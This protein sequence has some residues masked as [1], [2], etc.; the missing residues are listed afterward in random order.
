[1]Q[2]IYRT[3]FYNNIYHPSADQWSTVSTRIDSRVYGVQSTTATHILV[4]AAIHH[5]LLPHCIPWTPQGNGQPGADNV[6]PFPRN[7]LAGPIPV[8]SESSSFHQLIVR[9]AISAC[10]L[11]YLTVGR[12]VRYP[13]QTAIAA[14]QNES[15]QAVK[16]TTTYLTSYRHCL[17]TSKADS[18]MI[19][20]R[21]VPRHG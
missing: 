9:K 4:L 10:H 5:I 8:A 21:Q 16:Q 15:G 17:C 7:C 6:L 12:S 19:V 2:L 11:S 14:L 13:R 18:S 3:F 1:M 20:L